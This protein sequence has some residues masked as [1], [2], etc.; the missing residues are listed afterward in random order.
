MCF[1]AASV[2]RIILRMI[3]VSAVDVCPL[4][5]AD[6]IHIKVATIMWDC[7]VF[8]S[9]LQTMASD[10]DGNL[11]PRR[12][13]CAYFVMAL[14]LC[15]DLISSYIRGN[16]LASPMSVTVG[17]FDLF[18]DTAITSSITSQTVIALHFLYVSCRARSGRGWAYP[19]LR[20][21]LDSRASV[22][23]SK[24]S[25]NHSFDGRGSTSAVT[26]TS[27][28]ETIIEQSRDSE[29]ESLSAFM[30]LRRYILRFQQRHLSRCCA[31]VIP[32]VAFRD[33]GLGGDFEFA[34]ARPTFVLKCLLPLQRL[35]EKNPGAYF[36]VMLCCVTVPGMVCHA[37]LRG[38]AQGVALIFFSVCLLTMLLGYLSSALYG[39]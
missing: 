25:L 14:C 35:A 22:M 19:S 18:L 12:R 21:E 6:E 10:S 23:L 39:L 9:G 7:T 38:Q 13:R 8:L 17:F 11:A 36:S 33:V 29:V 1:L 27:Q 30:R 15:I 2:E 34:M 26:S 5:A 20:F 4:N 32:C 37:V 24:L 16:A 31:F 3:V 28:D